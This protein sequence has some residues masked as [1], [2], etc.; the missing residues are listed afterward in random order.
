MKRRSV[1]DRGSFFCVR[2]G[3]QV[4]SLRLMTSKLVSLVAEV[5]LHPTPLRHV[6]DISLLE[7]GKQKTTG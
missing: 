2:A 4:L 6:P 7:G 1:E 3:M 5:T